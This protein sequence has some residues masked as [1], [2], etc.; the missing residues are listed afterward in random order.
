M[1][2]FSDILD[3]VGAFEI[4]KQMEKFLHREAPPSAS[5]QTLSYFA[6]SYELAFGHL[7]GAVRD[8]WH[9]NGLMQAPLFY[10]A[11]HSIELHLKW[12]I[13]EFESYSGE[14]AKECGHDLLALWGELQKQQ[15][16][17]ADLPGRDDPWGKHVDKLIKHMHNIDPKGD[18]FRYPHSIGGKL[19]AYTRIEF[20]GLVRAHNHVTGYCGASLDVLGEYRDCYY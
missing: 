6:Y 7:A 11:R 13:E 1:S 14:K 3:E 19:F 20:E 8:R 15:F 4:P 17:L 10:L 5:D 18:S 16:D 9:S 2:S 12:A